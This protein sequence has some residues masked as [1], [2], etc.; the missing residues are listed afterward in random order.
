[1]MESG[2]INAGKLKNTPARLFDFAV[3]IRQCGAKAA[4]TFGARRIEK[5]RAQCLRP[6]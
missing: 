6:L 2:F 5:I 3:I 1:M 4:E